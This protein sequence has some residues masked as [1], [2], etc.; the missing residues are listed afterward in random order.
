MGRASRPPHHVRAAPLWNVR[1]AQKGCQAGKAGCLRSRSAFAAALQRGY[2]GVMNT[3]PIPHIPRARS[4]RD[5]LFEAGGGLGGLALSWLLARD[6]AAATKTTNPLAA[7]SG[8]HEATAKSI[9]FLFMVG[10]PSPIDLFDPK[11][12][13]KKRQGQPLPPSFGKP[14]SQFTQ[15]DTPLLA[16]TRVFKKHGKSGLEVSD[17]LPH[18][19]S[20]VDDIC[21][22]RACWCTNTVHAPAMYE[23]HSG[24]TF[25]GFPSLGSWVTYGLGSVSDT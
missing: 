13:L 6:A 4:R 9:I 11:P 10:G 2:P 25:M 1:Q 7:R 20:C 12:E 5:F 19:A 15:G 3:T 8:H 17:L 22:L 23:L 18:L 21:F 24:R 14:V 16:S